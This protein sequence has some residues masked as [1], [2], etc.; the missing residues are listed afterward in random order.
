MFPGLQQDPAPT[1]TLVLATLRARLLENNL[2]SKTSK[3]KVFGAHNLK[4]LLALVDWSGPKKAE[5]TEEERTEVA[6]GVSN[7]LQL[8]LGNVKH[9]V[10]FPEP[11][12]GCGERAGQTNPL[13]GEVVHGLMRPWERPA[14]CPVLTSLAA[15]CPGTL[16]ALL[17]RLAEAGEPRDAAA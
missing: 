16:P 3:M 15:A 14:L 17:G 9:G 10:I 8:L 11:E 4:P 1:V 12:L 13:A 6:E 2:V 7:F 5:V